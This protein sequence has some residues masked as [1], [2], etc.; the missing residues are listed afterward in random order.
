MIKGL[1]LLAGCMLAAAFFVGLEVTF[2]GH[3]TV[4]DPFGFAI[5]LGCGGI[6]IAFG[7]LLYT[8]K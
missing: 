8:T 2:T 4:V 5:I 7:V 3:S 6:C 1:L